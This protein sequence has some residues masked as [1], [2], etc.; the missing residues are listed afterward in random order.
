MVHCVGESLASVLGGAD[1]AVVE[2]RFWWW[3]LLVRA[4]WC[5]RGVVCPLKSG[6]FA[7]LKRRHQWLPSIGAVARL[8]LT[9]PLIAPLLLSL[10]LEVVLVVVAVVSAMFGGVFVFRSGKGVPHPHPGVQPRIDCRHTQHAQGQ[11]RRADRECF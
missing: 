4:L 9:V 11:V 5:E 6:A 7:K 10:L 2:D 1:H 3:W 8:L